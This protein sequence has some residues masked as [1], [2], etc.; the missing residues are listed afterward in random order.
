[1]IAEIRDAIRA[2]SARPTL[3]LRALPAA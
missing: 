3:K 2:G 1:V